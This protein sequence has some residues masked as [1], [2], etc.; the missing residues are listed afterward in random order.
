LIKEKIKHSLIL[1]SGAFQ[2]DF[3]KQKR[4]II[5]LNSEDIKIYCFDS[6]TYLNYLSQADLVITL[7][8][9]NSIIESVSR[10]GRPRA[11]ATAFPIVDFPE[12][13]GPI[14]IARGAIKPT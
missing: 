12:P 11:L 14:K 2:N 8:G 6:T 9:Y 1:F 4:K 13:M 3:K 7:G 10:N 5:D